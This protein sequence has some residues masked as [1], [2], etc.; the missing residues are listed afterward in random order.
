MAFHS[1]TNWS[2]HSTPPSCHSASNRLCSEISMY[3]N[4][5]SS[6]ACRQVKD[7]SRN[8]SVLESISSSSVLSSSSAISIT[9]RQVFLKSSVLSSYRAKLLT[10]AASMRSDMLA[11]QAGSSISRASCCCCA[12]L[13]LSSMGNSRTLPR[14]PNPLPKPEGRLSPLL[15]PPPL[16][17]LPSPPSLPLFSRTSFCRTSLGSTGIEMMGLGRKALCCLNQKLSVAVK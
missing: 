8:W 16:S 2:L 3:L 11:S 17:S 13:S 15:L 14:R 9:S 5:Q 12:S 7:S 1:V 6:S 4:A 10:C